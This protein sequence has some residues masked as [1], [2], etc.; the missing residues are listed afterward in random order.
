MLSTPKIKWLVSII[1]AGILLVLTLTVGDWGTNYSA[2]AMGV[3]VPIINSI[4][5]SRMPVRSPD[6]VV[7][8][9]GSIFGTEN[10]TAVRFSEVG[11][12]FDQTLHPPEV[13]EYGTSVNVTSTM[14]TEA[15]V[16]T[17]TVIISGRPEGVTIPE[18]PVWSFDLVSNELTFTVFQAQETFLPLMNR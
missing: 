2:N 15:T 16:Y 5:P 10:D 4:L 12:G 14:M 6:K 8:I 9:G 3:P 11:G 1:L 13:Y 7:V 18:L 17:V